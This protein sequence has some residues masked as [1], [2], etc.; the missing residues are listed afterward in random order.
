MAAAYAVSGVLRLRAEESARRAEPGAGHAAGRVGWAVSQL[1][2]AGPARRWCWPRPGSAPGSYGVRAGDLGTQVPRLL[3]AALV[4][5]P[6]V[7]AV[8]A[9]AVLL[10][11]LR[12]GRAWP[13]AGRRWRWPR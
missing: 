1:V 2:V 8:A 4:Q 10:F 11:G 7:L 13:A 5:L 12:P 3:G 6:A 9:V